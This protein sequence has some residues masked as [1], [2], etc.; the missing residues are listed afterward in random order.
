[1]K[2]ERQ[3]A[4]EPSFGGRK[5]CTKRGGADSTS[6]GPLA[7]GCSARFHPLDSGISS[8][9][10][11]PGSSPVLPTQALLPGTLWVKSGRREAE[12]ALDAACRV[13]EAGTRCQA[14]RT[15]IAC[16]WDQA[17][18]FRAALSLAGG[19][20]CPGP[21]FTEPRLCAHLRGGRSPPF[22]SGPGQPRPKPERA[23]GR[24]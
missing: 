18:R 11:R 20:P 6:L 9:H 23:E 13:S 7:G 10:G 24:V 4:L 17:S 8:S 14:W 15:P 19:P 21:V 16:G 3:T 5:H 2:P 12:S 22:S 1:M